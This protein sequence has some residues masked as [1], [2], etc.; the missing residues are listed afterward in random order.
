MY[1]SVLKLKVDTIYQ[2]NDGDGHET[3]SILDTE[4]CSRRRVVRSLALYTIY[5]VLANSGVTKVV[6]R[7]CRS[8]QETDFILS[9]VSF[10]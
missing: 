9:V 10:V 6:K 8:K 2:S 1:K 4:L 3:F 7:C 5:V